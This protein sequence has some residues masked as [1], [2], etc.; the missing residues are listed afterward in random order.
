MFLRNAKLM[1]FCLT[2][3]EY[4]TCSKKICIKQLQL[5]FTALKNYSCLI[6]IRYLCQYVRE[7]V[8]SIP[9]KSLYLSV[10]AKYIICIIILFI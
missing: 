3:I 8:A 9:C 5:F 7:I 10:L 2:Y 4:L 1:S 6:R